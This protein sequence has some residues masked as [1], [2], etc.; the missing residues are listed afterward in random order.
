MHINSNMLMGILKYRNTKRGRYRERVSTS[1][2]NQLNQLFL[3]IP[4]VFFILLIQV[5]FFLC[6][7]SS[8][9]ALLTCPRVSSFSSYVEVY[10][11]IS[12]SFNIFYLFN[13]NY[14]RFYNKKNSF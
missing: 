11:Y 13:N 12:I 2:H 10:F 4:F 8:F 7:A 3:Q 14:K 9:P 5:I 6:S 1:I